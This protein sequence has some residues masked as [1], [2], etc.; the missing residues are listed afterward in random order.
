MKALKTTN[1]GRTTTNSHALSL[2]FDPGLYVPP[3][4]VKTHKLLQ[5]CSK[6][7]DRLCLHWL[8]LV[9][10]TC[11]EQIVIRLVTSVIQS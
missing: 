9:V 4:H 3:T 6:A 8:F 1:Q 2:L 5:I 10:V 11:L 7:V